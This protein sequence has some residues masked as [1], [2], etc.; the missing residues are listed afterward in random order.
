MR[1]KKTGLPGYVKILLKLSVL[2]LCL[3]GLFVFAVFAGVFGHLQTINEL[4]DYRNATASVVLSNDGRPVGKFFHENRTNISSAEIPE[5][6]ADALI[7]TE[8][9]RFAEHRGIDTRSLFRVFF[10][11]VLLRDRSSGG[12]S[13][14]TQQLAKNMFGRRSYGPLTLPVNKTKEIILAIRLEKAFTK[15]EILT[16]YL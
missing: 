3:A 14:I 13:T 12:G 8:D 16:L 5:H 2:L 10:K 4:K 7:A 9:I 6:L 15:E 11:S 1:K